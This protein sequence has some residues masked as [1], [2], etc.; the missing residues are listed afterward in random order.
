MKS[1]SRS[2]PEPEAN[3]RGSTAAMRA[4]ACM[5]S[6]AGAESSM[7]VASLMITMRSSMTAGLGV[8]VPR[9]GD[10]ALPAWQPAN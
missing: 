1:T 8:T 5:T 3:L 2:A 6:W 10:Q 7:Q 4:W 9:S